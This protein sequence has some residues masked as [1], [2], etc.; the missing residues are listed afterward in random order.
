MRGLA[1]F[2]GCISLLLLAVMAGIKPPHVA[3]NGPTYRSVES[4]VSSREQ[5][6]ATPTV[7]E[8]AMKA[9]RGR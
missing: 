1:I 8:S 6:M 2:Y 7:S 3:Q 4:A 9:V 5:V